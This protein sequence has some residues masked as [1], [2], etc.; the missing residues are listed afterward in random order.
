MIT[1][2]S[3]P[4]CPAHTRSY[5]MTSSQSEQCNTSSVTCS[6]CVVSREQNKSANKPHTTNHTRCVPHAP[7]TRRHTRYPDPASVGGLFRF[8]LRRTYLRYKSLRHHPR[9]SLSCTISAIRTLRHLL[10]ELHADCFLVPPICPSSDVGVP[11][12]PVTSG[13]LQ[14]HCT[15]RILALVA[16]NCAARYSDTCW[17]PFQPHHARDPSTIPAVTGPLPPGHCQSTRQNKEARS[18]ASAN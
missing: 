12:T 11:H 18:G 1:S 8:G 6:V 4:L 3:W 14:V 13:C 15:I 2:R 9:T 10:A 7:Q 16:L 17:P 5:S